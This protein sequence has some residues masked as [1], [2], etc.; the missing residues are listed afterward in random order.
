MLKRRILNLTAAASTSRIP[1]LSAS[2]DRTVTMTDEQAAQATAR[3]M[4]GAIGQ[5]DHLDRGHGTST[6][7][8]PFTPRR[9]PHQARQ[10]GGSWL[11]IPGQF[12][13]SA[14]APIPATADVAQAQV[15]PRGTGSDRGS[16]FP[17]G[18]WPLPG[19]PVSGG[20]H[21]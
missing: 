1:A 2:S 20:P 12:Y 8:G 4:R 3:Q 6:V 18:I 17:E 11:D 16:Q 13:L 9:S 15:S 5:V 21:A 14:A 10:A 19:T 7:A